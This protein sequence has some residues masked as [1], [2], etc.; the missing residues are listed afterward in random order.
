MIAGTSCATGKFFNL[1]RFTKSRFE[2]PAGGGGQLPYWFEESLLAYVRET[3][4]IRL[5]QENLISEASMR[6]PHTKA[7]FDILERGQGELWLAL[8][9]RHYMCWFADMERRIS[10]GHVDV[11]ALLQQVEQH[12]RLLEDRDV[13]LEE[14]RNDGSW[15]R[16]WRQAFSDFR[17]LLG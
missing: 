9:W 4:I 12:W 3:D 15:V 14:P 2:E 1:R 7:I 16:P 13:L 10:R 5:R 6:N 11:R 8:S 17:K